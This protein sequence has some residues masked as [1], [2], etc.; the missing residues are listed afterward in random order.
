MADLSAQAPEST[1]APRPIRWFDALRERAPAFREPGSGSW[2]VTRYDDV[3]ALL[4]DPRLA[5]QPVAAPDEPPATARARLDALIAKWPAFTDPPHHTVLRRLM[6]PLFQPRQIDAAARAVG[7][8]LRGGPDIETPQRLRD[9]I[10][11]GLTRLLGAEPADYGALSLWAEAILA[12]MSGQE[13]T[14]Q[15][16]TEALTAYAALGEY[17][18][19]AVADRRGPLGA[20]LGDERRSGAIDRD[21]AVAIYA[22]VLTGAIEPTLSVAMYAVERIRADPGLWSDFTA[23]RDRFV[24]EL[25]RLAAPFHFAVRFAKDPIDLHGKTIRAGDQVVLVLLAANRDP[26]RFPDPERIRT[27]REGPFHLSFGKGRHACIGAPLARRAVTAL[28]E[29]TGVDALTAMR[30]RTDGWDIGPGMRRW[31]V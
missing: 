30:L 13:A 8:A 19:A 2:F 29:S 4:T 11:A 16:L 26:R 22:Q 14:E 3:A 27:D 9:A 21:D 1:A 28:L 7:E 5:A 15:R 10:G 6:H 20:A 24:E 17:V 23:H 31:L 12:P 25:I 18:D